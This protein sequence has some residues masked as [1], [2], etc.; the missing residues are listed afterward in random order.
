MVFVSTTVPNVDEYLA[1][2]PTSEGHGIEKAL[3]S[4]TNVSKNVQCKARATRHRISVLYR[5]ENLESTSLTPAE[6][7]ILPPSDKALANSQIHA[8][9]YATKEYSATSLRFDM[10][11]RVR[12]VKF[13][14][15]LIT[16]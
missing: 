15:L 7:T 3:Y 8:D 12:T 13:S 16:T 9:K 2:L 14:R 1:F 5:L 10:L 6:M 4:K 11:Q